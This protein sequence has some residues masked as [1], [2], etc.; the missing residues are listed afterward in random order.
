MAPS[1]KLGQTDCLHSLKDLWKKYHNFNFRFVGCAPE[2]L[3]VQDVAACTRAPAC[4]CVRAFTA[5]ASRVYS[6]L[7]SFGNLTPLLCFQTR[8]ARW[9]LQRDMFQSCDHVGGPAGGCR[10][11]IARWRGVARRKEAGMVLK[12]VW[13][14]RE[15]GGRL[16]SGVVVQGKVA[17][18]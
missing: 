11:C 16:A 18:R 4:E 2:Q 8:S 7:L 13:N 1:P 9:R 12:G 10:S 3:S 17:Y 6:N 5:F 15:E 14:E